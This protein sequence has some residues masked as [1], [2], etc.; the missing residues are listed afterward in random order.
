MDMLA[1][2]EK[3]GIQTLR[4]RIAAGDYM[5]GDAL[6]SEPRLK[7]EFGVSTITVR[8]AIH[9]LALD[10]LIDSRQGIGNIVRES[11]DSS[12]LVDMSSFTT[13]VTHGKLRLVRTLLVDETVPAASDIAGRL[14][15]QPGSMLRRLVRLD[16]EDNAPLSI[17]EVSIPPALASAITSGIAA[18]PTFMHLWQGASGLQLVR[19]QYEIWA[20]KSS[21]DDQQVLR[22]EP[23]CPVLVTGELIQR[24]VTTGVLPMPMAI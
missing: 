16:R 17:D 6:P 12:V 24:I 19:A 7:E 23:D 4:E 8:R 18:S 20:E 10:G 15:V 13:D 22:I 11:A 2:G 5:P 1:T 9:E 21:A 3:T 14:H